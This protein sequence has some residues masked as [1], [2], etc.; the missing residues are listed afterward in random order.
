MVAYP[1]C[2]Q[3]GMGSA[4]DTQMFQERAAALLTAFAQAPTP[5][6]LIADAKLYH[7]ANA[8]TLATLGLI[9]RMP[10]PLK[11]VA[12][13]ITQ[14]LTADLWQRLDETTR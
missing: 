14:A 12:Q 7:E 13:V 1:W 9:T 2:A 3:A 8:P 10:G 5:R 6:Y 4:S 11:L